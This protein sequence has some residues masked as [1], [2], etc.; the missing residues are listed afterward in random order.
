MPDQCP[1]A[2]HLPIENNS[3]KTSSSPKRSHH[4]RY[5][6]GRNTRR[7]S[8]NL[9]QA[10]LPLRRGTPEGNNVAN[11]RSH[12]PSSPVKT[13]YI[14]E[15]QQPQAKVDRLPQQGVSSDLHDGFNT[16]G[17]V[18]AAD[19]NIQ[20]EGSETATASACTSPASSTKRFSPTTAA[21]P[22]VA[23]PIVPPPKQ[24]DSNN[25]VPPASAVSIVVGADDM[26]GVTFGAEPPRLRFSLSPAC[27]TKNLQSGEGPAEPTGAKIHAFLPTTDV[28]G[29]QKVDSNVQ[30]S[31]L[32]N[33]G[34]Y[35][36]CIVFVFFVRLC[37]TM[38][39]AGRL[40]RLLSLFFLE[41]FAFLLRV[42]V[43]GTSCV[44]FPSKFL[45]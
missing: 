6:H 26:V 44:V 19:E 2:E 15:K 29:G 8:L 41:G 23:Q 7:A 3:G 31:S 12:V 18:A 43:N 40:L 28:A 27:D 4:G 38:M 22:G 33:R 1:V 14:L 24:E 35:P 30:V 10:M 9:L 36:H 37:R 34:R 13:P 20:R 21:V 45:L 17:A 16:F 42:L 25:D 11:Q 5:T 39:D 32:L